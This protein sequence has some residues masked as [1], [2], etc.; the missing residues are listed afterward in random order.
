M[1]PRI[2]V[3]CQCPTPCSVSRSLFIVRRCFLSHTG[4]L[5][6]K[7]KTARTATDWTDDE[8]PG[9]GTQDQALARLA[10][11]LD[12]PSTSASLALPSKYSLS[13][14]ALSS[15]LCSVFP[16]PRRVSSL[17]LPGHS[18]SLLSCSLSLLLLFF[19]SFSHSFGWARF[20]FPPRVLR[21]RVSLPSAS[22]LFLF[23]CGG[24]E[25]VR[26]RLPGLAQIRGWR[27][28]VL[29]PLRSSSPSERGWGSTGLFPHTTLP[30]LTAEW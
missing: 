23:L 15:R 9:P 16:V 20:P 19:F 8:D 5:P 6:G 13:V 26:W 27:P 21:V 7:M 29:L 25:F 22:L 3:T 14:W 1:T 4:T 2:S 12:D 10:E 11:G 18:L 30:N 28:P 24:S 17:A